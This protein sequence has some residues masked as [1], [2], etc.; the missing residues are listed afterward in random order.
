MPY[1]EPRR[2]QNGVITSY[3]LVVSAGLD[4]DGKQI[5]RR[6][7][8]TPPSRDMSEAQMEREA[9]AAAYK[10]EDQIK[11]GYSLDNNQT[12]AEY[13][14]YVMDLKERIGVKTSTLDRYLDML[15]RINAAIGHLKLCNIRPQHLND[16]Y[17][18]MMENAVR[19][20][21]AR[22]VAKRTLA[23]RLKREKISKAELGRRAG[24][25]AST[26]TAATRGDPLRIA[27]AEAIANALKTS[28]KDLFTFQDNTTPLSSKTILEHHRLISTIL[29]QADKE[30]LIPFN[31]AEKATPPKVKRSSPDYYQP[32]EMDE[33]L[34]ALENAPIKWK[35][36]TYLLIDTGC[37]RGEI[38]GLKWDRINFET[39]VI[40]IDSNLLYSANIGIYEDT[41]KT[42]EV[43]AIKIAPQTLEV[44]QK[45]KQAYD[46]L[47]EDNGDR[48]ANAPYVFVR[49]DGSPMHPD[50]ITDWLR[51][52]SRKYDLPHIHPHAFRHTAAST[53]IAN[54]VDL[55]TT[56]AELGHANANTTAMIYAHQIAVARATASNVRAG[57]FANRK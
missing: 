47:K 38:M 5:R 4:Q 6:S 37:R 30:L 25:A 3:R 33:I 51:N 18:D 57:V 20:D 55:V 52:F 7:L 49:D 56:A 44:L 29:G 21:S 48:W 8:W 22:A 28:T 11:K 46:Q 12:F 45:W 34:N 35:A 15:P 24:V 23:T 26:I 10:F 9:T 50:S 53:M 42:G 14:Q 41:T 39:G 40:T 36:I 19:S 13:A 17:K 2:N 54:G 27:T 32:E 43:R 31:P 1:I 16:F